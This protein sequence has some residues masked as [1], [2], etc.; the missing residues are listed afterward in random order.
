MK[1]RNTLPSLLILMLAGTG[2]LAAQTES[3]D[4][5]SYPGYEELDELVIEAER[6]VIQSDG[7]KTTY[8][9]DED[10]SAGSSNALEIL[11]K[12]P[13]V[14]VDGD[15]NVRLNGQGNFK[16]QVNGLDNPMLQQY[17]DRILQAM[18]ASMIVKIEVITEPGAKQ[19]AEGGAGIINII[20][21]RKRQTDG[22]SGTLQARLTQREVGPSANVIVKKNKVT[23]SAGLNYQW[24]FGKQK[25]SQ[26]STI[27]YL[28]GNDT[29]SLVSTAS[30]SSDYKYLSGN[31]DLSWEPNEK[32]LF[33]FGANVMDMGAD[34]DN[35]LGTTRR[36]DTAGSPLWSYSQQGY[37]SMKM[38]N[39]S[40]NGSYRH[41]FAPE[42]NYLILSYLFNYGRTLLDITQWTDL[43]SQLQFVDPFE[44]RA[45]ANFNR[46]HTVQID[47]ANDFKS[48]H[49]LLEVGAKGIFRHN[50]ARATYLTGNDEDSLMPSP[51]QD[52]YIAQPQD[53][54]AGYATYTGKFSALTVLAGLRYEHTRMGIT[55]FY[56]SDRSFI[57][58]LND[59]VPN[60]ALT[61]TFGPATN[62]RAAYQMRIS[63]PSI[64]QVNPFE[65]ALTP[66]EVR[67]GNPDLESEKSHKVSLTFSDFGR[68]FGG[69][70]GVEYTFVN[71]AISGY[72]Y[73]LPVDGLDV[74]YTSY[75]NIGRTHNVAL[76]GFCTWS[77]IHNMNLM[78][79][80]RLAY[81]TLRSPAEG[82]R[83]HGWSGNIGGSWNYSVA[84]V[85][86]FS[87]YGG[88]NSRSVTLQGYSSGY[89]YYGLSASRDFLKDRSLT[90]SLSANN[91]LCKEMSFRSHSRT[92]DTESY[93]TGKNLSAWNV[94][95]S[96]AWKFGSL[97]AKVKN[98]GADLN[99]DDINKSSNKS[100]SSGF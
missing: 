2:S 32:N 76:T 50:N 75:G 94:G 83:N 80:G 98:T 59:W 6:P 97:Q 96:I 5:L 41:N 16:F 49:H 93:S 60:A 12:V 3:A 72:Q 43:S 81:N 27:H 11:K 51:D 70:I 69:N 38:L 21:E 25:G 63:R 58:R 17:A 67:K 4:T 74:L 91:F 48:E 85:N 36:F 52:S 66:F 99:N 9:V 34:M 8:N 71:N 56:D 62:L 31:F 13:M 77:I 22:Y 39:V 86:K 92:H 78:L 90:L 57:N 55:D 79:N 20:T 84:E 15:G 100:S 19:D 73:L 42:G 61:W 47:Y 44:S 26:E 46:G 7:A 40:A 28:T 37:G 30:Q 24:C 45:A 18:P 87:A 35:I 10:P 53:I 33:T 54:Y 68:V 64:D 23:F 14:S 88:W 82:Y 29:G 1:I 95:I 89:Y 65:L